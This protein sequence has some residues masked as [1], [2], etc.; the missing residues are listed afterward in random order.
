MELILR[1]KDE[2]KLDSLLNALRRLIAS[3]GIDVVIE[4]PE[5]GIVLESAANDFDWA[6]FHE[7]LDRPKRHPDSPELSEEEEAALI[8]QEIK[9][10]RAEDRVT[11]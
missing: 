1:L 3:E 7:I 4:S 5:S 9:A 2:S 8:N 11:Q 6:R 10:M